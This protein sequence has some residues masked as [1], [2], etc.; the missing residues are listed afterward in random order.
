[1]Y[2]FHIKNKHDNNLIILFTDA[3]S[4]MYEIESEYVYEDCIKDK[5]I[6]DFRNYS[7]KPKYYNY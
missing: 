5:E 6:I 3:D 4:L 1:M 2:E 7:A